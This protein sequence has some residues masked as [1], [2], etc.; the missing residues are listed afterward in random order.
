MS[1]INPDPHQGGYTF[2]PIKRVTAFFP[3]G[4][5][6]RKVLDALSEAGFAREQ[7]EVFVGD[8]GASKLDLSGEE[9]GIVVQIMRGLER[10]FADEAEVVQRADQLL[11]SGGTLVAVFTEGD[12]AKKNRAAEILK[13]FN[14]QGVRYWG[15][16]TIEQL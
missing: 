2:L 6:I 5:E 11:R 14:G 8:E 15:N 1:R 12:D 3:P 9:H 13:A 7:I 10:I 4:Q 16:W